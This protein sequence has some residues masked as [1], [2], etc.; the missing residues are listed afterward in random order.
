MNFFL[1][2]NWTRIRTTSALNI[3]LAL[4][5]NKTRLVLVGHIEAGLTSLWTM[6]TRHHSLKGFWIFFPL[7]FN[8]LCVADKAKLDLLF[9]ETCRYLL[10]LIS[11]QVVWHVTSVVRESTVVWFIAISSSRPNHMNEYNSFFCPN[12]LS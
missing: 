2:C 8:F 9:N 11:I 5:M 6:L 1:G 4:L 7:S 3:R 10:Y 12:F